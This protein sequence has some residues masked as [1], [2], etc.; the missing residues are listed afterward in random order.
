LYLNHVIITGDSFLAFI[1][2]SLDYIVVGLQKMLK[3]S[4]QTIIFLFL[5][6]IEVY[7]IGYKE[8]VS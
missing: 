7:Y 4:L 5:K 3:E 8:K 2:P 1:D 6:Q